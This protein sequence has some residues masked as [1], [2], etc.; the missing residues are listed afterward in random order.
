MQS[1]DLLEEIFSSSTGNFNKKVHVYAGTY[2]RACVF[3]MQM[4]EWIA[5][6]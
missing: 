1:W 6:Y 3:F 4:Y 5:A 2:V